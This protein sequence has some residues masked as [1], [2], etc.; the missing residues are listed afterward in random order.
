MNLAV[1]PQKM[2]RGLKF[3][4]KEAE[5]MYYICS[6]NKGSDQLCRNSAADLHLPFHICKKQ[7]SI[8]TRL[9]MVLHVPGI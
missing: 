5:G 3:Q 9:I 7:V 2:V 4:I 6:E 8:M 1:Q